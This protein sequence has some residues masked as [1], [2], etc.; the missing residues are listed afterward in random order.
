MQTAKKVILKEYIKR[1]N[2][3]GEFVYVDIPSAPT[4]GNSSTLT[5][6][7]PGNITSGTTQR[8]L[9]SG[10]W[11]Q[12]RLFGLTGTELTPKLVTNLDG[13]HRITGA[14][15]NH[16]LANSSGGDHFIVHGKS[17]SEP[18]VIDGNNICTGGV[19]LTA[20]AGGIHG[21][22]K[23]IVV[24]DTTFASLFMNS[25]GILS[26]GDAST[27]PISD[28]FYQD[29]ELSHVRAFGPHGET[30]YNGRTQKDSAAI[31]NNYTERHG[32]GY[33]SGW[34]L[35]QWNWHKNLLLENLTL[36]N[37]GLLLESS[38]DNCVQFQNVVAIIRNCI[39]HAAPSLCN[40]F[41]M[42]ILFDNCVFVWSKNQPGYHGD[43]LTAYG[44][45]ARITPTPTYTRYQNCEF[46]SLGGSPYIFQVAEKTSNFDVLNCKARGAG[47]Y[48]LD[49]RGG[50]SSNAINT[51]GSIIVANSNSN[52]PIPTYTNMDPEQYQTHGLLTEWY[53]YNKGRGY[54]TPMAA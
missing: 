47:A 46:I 34:D 48:I 18:Y 41:A 50:G 1:R 43:Y 22:Y 8:K 20:T 38:Q 19:Q 5:Y 51:T 28:V 27:P 35:G 2:E 12:A 14:F 7:N 3:Q 39:F 45:G 44:T 33:G 11:E 49:S 17:P 52:I 32:L 15:A 54:R 36:Y 40:I 37:G 24:K 26:G 13:N 9:L 23:N 42:N 30:R 16:A 29:I 21:K 4:D 31:F 53:H 25:N 6:T 10:V